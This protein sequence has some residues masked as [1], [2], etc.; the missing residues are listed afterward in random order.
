M[1]L[2]I[3]LP[4]ASLDCSFQDRQA[5]EMSFMILPFKNLKKGS[6]FLSWTLAW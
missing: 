2:A 4:G 3:H 6:N 1:R 5:E